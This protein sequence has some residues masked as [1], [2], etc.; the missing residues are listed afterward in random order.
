MGAVF[1]S[2]SQQQQDE[3]PKARNLT[4]KAFTDDL[5]LH[6]AAGSNDIE[7]VKSIL[8]R[9][10]TWDIDAI[11]GNYK[12][13][14]H[15]AAEKGQLAMVAFLIEKGANIH[16]WTSGFKT[17]LHVACRYGCTDVCVYLL[18]QGADP[19]MRDYQDKTPIGTRRA[20]IM[21]TTHIHDTYIPDA[22]IY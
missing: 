8:S 11:D 1:S 6:R 12:T 22:H 20:H 21:R 16:A 15:R 14:L 19:Y 4:K 5:S 3:E 9:E 2:T 7:V 17:P 18:D 10:P 13:G